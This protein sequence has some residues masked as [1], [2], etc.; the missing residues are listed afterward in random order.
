EEYPITVGIHSSPSVCDINGD[1]MLDLLVGNQ[2]GGLE[3]F[4][5]IQKKINNEILDTQPSLDVTIY[6]IPTK[7]NLYVQIKEE[8]VKYAI[9]DMRG[10]CVLSGLLKGKKNASSTHLISLQT[11]FKGVFV[12]VLSTAQGQRSQKIIKI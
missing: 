5:G 2:A 8:N 3:F 11:L 10:Q 9:Y 6:P 12:L 1:G 4:E 7:D